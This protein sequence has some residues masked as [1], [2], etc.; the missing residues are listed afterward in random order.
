M[1]VLTA[2]RR[3]FL[4]LFSVLNPG[5]IT[6]RHHYAG[7]PFRLHSFR[8]KGYWFYGKRREPE[9]MRFFAACVEPGDTV[10]EVGGHIGYVSVY[11]AGLVGPEG[12]LWVLE[13]GENNLPYLERNT[14]SLPNVTVVAKG[15]A[16]IDGELTL[17]T[18]DLT[19]QNNSF[20]KDYDVLEGNARS[21]NRRP[22]VA[23]RRVPVATLDALV[24][25]NGLKP[26][27]VKID[28]EGFERRVLEGMPAVLSGD[29]PA[30]MVEVTREP[31]AVL[32]LLAGHG[33]R[34]Y[35]RSGVPI[36]EAADMRD[37]VFGLH[38]DVHGEKIG[39][40]GFEGERKVTA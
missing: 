17:Y 31:E 21:A 23:E 25:E 16:D 18:E 26:S 30:L 14:R 24:R 3:V 9:T 33:Y 1:S 12:R 29:K 37:N 28:V 10:V 22:R 15:A 11:L 27:L 13:P 40:L 39:K 32:A 6:I 2:L 35:D 8:H 36:K 19:G 4:P 20:V 38:P 5:D 7:T 34:C